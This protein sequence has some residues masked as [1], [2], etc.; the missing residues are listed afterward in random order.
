MTNPD[1]TE[2][3]AILDRSG[4]MELVKTDTEGAFN[5]YVDE[6]RAVPG[7]ATLSLVQ[8][9]DRIETV[10]RN[11]RL[12]SV[13]A[14]SLRPRG[15]TALYDAIG[16]TVVE[17]GEKLEQLPENQRPGKVIVVILTDGLENSSKDWTADRL[18]PLIKEQIEKYGWT[19][20]YL[21]ANQDAVFE[22]DKI[23]ISSQSSLS[24]NTANMGATV[25][26]AS[27]A[28]T[29]SRSG[30]FTGFTE[31]DRAAAS[32]LVKKDSGDMD[33]GAATGTSD[34]RKKNVGWKPKSRSSA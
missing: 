29:A 28:T 31:A 30:L 7:E 1:L 2:I 26:A 21:G 6:Q 15:M 8:F 27:R 12:D 20:L 17:N 5:A 10:Y 24:Y 16:R 11:K 34:Q 25:A 19:F 33:T 3:I 9:D 23:G 14:L 32:G 22:G 4:S 13:P 18:K